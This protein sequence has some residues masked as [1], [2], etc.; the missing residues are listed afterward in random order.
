MHQLATIYRFIK[1]CSIFYI[2]QIELLLCIAVCFVAHHALSVVMLY[3][4]YAY[5]TYI[6]RGKQARQLTIQTAHD[7]YVV[8]I[9]D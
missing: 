6:S 7:I 1:F 8:L 5:C 4:T 2:L 3:C 9:A